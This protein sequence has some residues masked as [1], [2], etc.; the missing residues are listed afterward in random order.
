MT[1]TAAPAGGTSLVV[2]DSGSGVP[3]V[4]LHGE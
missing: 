2:E 1:A 3:L 4:L